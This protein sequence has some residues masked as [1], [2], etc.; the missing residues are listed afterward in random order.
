MHVYGSVCVCARIY[1][2]IYM[3]RASMYVF[4]RRKGQDCWSHVRAAVLMCT[5]YMPCCTCNQHSEGSKRTCSCGWSVYI[6]TCIIP[7]E[8]L[9]G[10]RHTFRVLAPWTVMAASSTDVPTDPGHKLDPEDNLAAFAL[11]EA[12]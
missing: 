3:L 9:L 5:I 2:Y 8:L 6:Y 10:A 12:A 4:D 11:V 7:C 1:V